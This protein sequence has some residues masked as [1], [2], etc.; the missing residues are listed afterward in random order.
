MAIKTFTT[1]EVLTASDTNTY[2]ANAGLDYITAGTVTA[3][4]RLNIPS[5]FSA[6]YAAYR[7][8]VTNLTHSTANNLIMRFS[9]SGSD[10]AGVNYYTQRSEVTGGAVSGV[11]ITASSAIFPTYANSSAGSFVSLSFDVINPFAT[12]PTTVSGGASRIDASTGLYM[13]T[14]SGLLNDT[15]SYNGISLV[16]NTGNITCTMRVY[17][18]RQA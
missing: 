5:C 15:T 8:V 10:T 1:G 17:G 6:T 16:G 13:V 9:A 12:T 18:Y 4:N 2:L 7:V 3:Q 14:F 11:S